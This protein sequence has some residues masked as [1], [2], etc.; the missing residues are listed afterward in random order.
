MKLV[1]F[2]SC[3]GSFDDEL[4]LPLLTK[5]LIVLNFSIPQADLRVAALFAIVD[6]A[7]QWSHVSWLKFQQSVFE[8]HESV[9]T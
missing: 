4:S 9:E 7:T 2:C 8:C 5:V 3:C 6:Y 1:E